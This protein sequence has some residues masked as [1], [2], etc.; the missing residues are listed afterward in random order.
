MW[1]KLKISI[2][3]ISLVLICGC[4]ISSKQSMP[5]ASVIDK[6]ESS[7]FVGSKTKPVTYQISAVDKLMNDAKNLQ[8]SGQPVKAIATLERAL[9][10][11]PRN[12]FIW[13]QM[14]QL[15]YSQQQYKEAESLALR[16]NQYVGS[17][18]VLSHSNWLLIA[19]ARAKLGDKA[20]SIAA[21]KKIGK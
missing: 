12:P 10:I 14:A 16:S 8:K 6:S 4:S 3:S 17:N 11:K 9:R 5:R 13:S 20:G 18:V 21:R 15:R 1:L 2:I 7:Q 19:N